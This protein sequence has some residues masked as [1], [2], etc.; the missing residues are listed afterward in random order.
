MTPRKRIVG[1]LSASVF[2]ATMALAR[3]THATPDA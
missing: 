3:D 1:L 2:V